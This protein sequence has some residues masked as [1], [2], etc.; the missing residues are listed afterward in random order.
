MLGI[1]IPCCHAIK[2]RAFC[3]WQRSQREKK[4]MSNK[5][6]SE[7][8]PDYLDVLKELHDYSHLHRL[9][10]TAVADVE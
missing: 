9:G 2:P 10:P 4:R 1:D 3:N 6:A 5:H 7:Y 8:R